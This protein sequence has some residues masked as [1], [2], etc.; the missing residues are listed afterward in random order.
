[1]KQN[2]GS[3]YCDGVLVSRRRCWLVVEEI[4][5]LGECDFFGLGDK[6]WICSEF[7]LVFN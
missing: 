6:D 2:Q 4:P 7:E 1:M 5:A 3:T